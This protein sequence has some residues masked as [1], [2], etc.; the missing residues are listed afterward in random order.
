MS[1]KRWLAMFCC[2]VALVVGLYGLANVV[3]D[4]F[5]VFGDPLFGWYSFNMTNNP[6]VAKIAYLEKHHDRY[7]SY[8]VGS[9]S[10]NGYPVEVLN[11]Y[12]DARFFN[13]FFYG[14]DM[15]DI[16]ATA[17]YIVEHYEPKN[18]VVNLG[19]TEAAEY[20]SKS[21]DGMN[22]LHYKVEG[23]SPFVFYKSFFLK[24]YRYLTAKVRDWRKRTRLP[25]IFNVFL[26]DTGEYDK[27]VRDVEPV[28]SL[29]E[30][31]DE[32][33][34]FTHSSITPP[35]TAFHYTQE[36]LSTLRNIREMCREKGV[37]CIFIFPPIFRSQLEGYNKDQLA[38]YM[39]GL[40]GAV[41]FWDFSDTC[42][43]DDPRY[44]YDV[45]HFRNAVGRMILARIFG[46]EK[47]YYPEDFGG[48][49]TSA[50]VQEHV[51][52]F[53]APKAPVPHTENLPI[54]LYHN[55]SD[56]DDPW[57]ISPEAFEAHMKA[58][59]A[60]G[61]TSVGFGDVFDYVWRGKPLPEKPVCITFDDGYLSNYTEAY[62]TLK[63]YHFKATMFVIG[64]TVGQTQHYKDTEFPI[65]PHFGWEHARK[66]TASGLIDI[67][68]H[69][70]DMHQH[71]QYDAPNPRESVLAYEN[72]TEKEYLEALAADHKLINDTLFAELGHYS[73]VVAYPKGEFDVRSAAVL[74]SLGVKITLGTKPGTNVLVKGLPQCLY[75]M[76]RYDASGATVEQILQYCGGK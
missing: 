71:P 12:L 19:L 27:R 26:A 41:D 5:G 44:F 36:C 74:S 65:T 7:D 63:Q 45:T 33:P 53:G 70:F 37:N 25:Q 68:S 72:E 42:I 69:T 3:I 76:C 66:M 1:A 46:D 56:K 22:D 62:P 20:N 67:E 61:Y 2:T 31:L 39:T 35:E 58:L 32:N 8:I 16:G 47:V 9:S 15:Y 43:S 34:C 23:S 55:L 40:A 24:N 48:L 49:V 29:A 11:E 10:A 17:R 50:N 59:H 13:A 64:A 6:R 38:S 30:Y 73:E 51:R 75:G 60:A 18:L 14:C 4:P 28:G 52:R 21:D 57:A 54:L